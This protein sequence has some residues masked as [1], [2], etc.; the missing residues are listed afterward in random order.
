[1]EV[2]VLVEVELVG[3]EEEREEDEPS[4][5]SLS[6]KASFADAR[7]RVVVEAF[8]PAAADGDTTSSSSESSPSC[9][10]MASNARFSSADIFSSLPLSL[11]LS[12]NALNQCTTCVLR[13]TLLRRVYRQASRHT[14]PLSAAAF[15]YFS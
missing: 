6:L 1:V 12:S 11:S 9:A 4:S 2:E 10:N 5:L 13:Y 15:R 7:G 14:I 8:A 3:E